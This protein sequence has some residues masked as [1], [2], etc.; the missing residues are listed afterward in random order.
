[1]AKYPSTT[2]FWYCFQK[3]YQKQ[4]ALSKLSDKILPN[5]EVMTEN[6]CSVTKKKDSAFESVAKKR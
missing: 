3:C 4:V 5:L 6:F 1:M 2:C